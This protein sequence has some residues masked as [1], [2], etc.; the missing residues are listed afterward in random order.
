VLC[1][2]LGE[3]FLDLPFADMRV[4]DM[5]LGDDGVGQNLLRQILA[6]ERPELESRNQSLAKDIS[7]LHCRLVH[8][9]VRCLCCFFSCKT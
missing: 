5:S 7:H 6:I 4:I 9:Q 2:I 3:G 8:E 1:V